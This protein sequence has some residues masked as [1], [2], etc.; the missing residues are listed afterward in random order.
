M[1][2]VCVY[3]LNLCPVYLRTTVRLTFTVDPDTHIE[4]LQQAEE[5][6]FE[7]TSNWACKIAITGTNIAGQAPA[8]FGPKTNSFREH[9]KQPATNTIRITLFW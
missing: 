9:D 4:A 6:I 7:G 3:S 8:F 5:S 2:G 1:Y